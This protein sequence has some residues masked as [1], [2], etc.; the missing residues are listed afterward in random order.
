MLQELLKKQPSNLGYFCNFI[1]ANHRTMV[2]KKIAKSGHPVRHVLK[3]FADMYVG[4]S[5][6]EILDLEVACRTIKM[7]KE[8]WCYHQLTRLG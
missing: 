2:A 5:P 3:G 8:R 4:V 7:A 1:K 6:I